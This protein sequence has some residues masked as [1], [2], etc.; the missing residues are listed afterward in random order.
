MK[1]KFFVESNIFASVFLRGL[2]FDTLFNKHTIKK[3]KLEKIA[4]FSVSD[5]K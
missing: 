3:N 2:G 5:E 4:V 1:Q